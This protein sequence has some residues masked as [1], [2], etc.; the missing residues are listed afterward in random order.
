LNP[1]GGLL[2]PLI[3]GIGIQAILSGCASAPRY[4]A[5]EAI[6]KGE[7]PRF[8]P[9]PDS[10]RAQ[11]ELSSLAKGRKGSV[12]AAFLARPWKQYK[13][14]LYGLPGMVAAGFLWNPDQWTLVLFEREG[15]LE[16]AGERVDIAELGLRDVSVHDLF[17]FLWGDFFP[18]S[19]VGDAPAT[20]GDPVVDSAAH[21][22]GVP[23]GLRNLGKGSFSY[24]AQGAEWRM[25]LDEKTGLPREAWRAD[26]AFRI[27]YSDYRAAGSEGARRPVPRK[28]R[29]YRGREAILEIRVQNVEDDPHWK[30]NPFFLKV[31]KGF[32]RLEQVE[33]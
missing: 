13:L 21:A 3:L 17:S 20:E 15:Y 2:Y 19:P 25:D 29:I 30:R 27:A 23:D 18:G 6:L 9:A 24:P 32:Q 4:P 14:D 5:G 28:V 22:A 11:L 26:S 10:L 33:R 7:T 8:P 16:G 31:P 1:R 12:N